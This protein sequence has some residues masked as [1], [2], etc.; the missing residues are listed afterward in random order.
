MDF[1]HPT[2]HFLILTLLY[3]IAAVLI[4]LRFWLSGD[5]YLLNCEINCYETTALSENLLQSTV[6]APLE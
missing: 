5:I 1:N 4:F 3:C 6:V 2:N